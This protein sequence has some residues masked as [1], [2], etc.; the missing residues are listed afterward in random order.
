MCVFF[1]E[2]EILTQKIELSP[3]QLFVLP[4]QRQQLLIV[5]GIG[6]S[7]RSRQSYAL[8]SR[9]SRESLR[10]SP[11]SLHWHV[12][13][14]SFIPQSL[15][16]TCFDIVILWMFCDASCCFKFSCFCWYGM[17]FAE[18]RAGSTRWGPSV[19]QWRMPRIPDTFLIL[20]KI[21]FHVYNVYNSL[22]PASSSVQYFDSECLYKS[23]PITGPWP[24]ALACS[25]ATVSCA[26]ESSDFKRVTSGQPTG[27]LAQTVSTHFD[28]KVGVPTIVRKTSWQHLS[29]FRFST[30]YIFLR[31]CTVDCSI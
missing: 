29:I 11:G 25:L 7:R 1:G 17:K 18:S 8:P 4:L 12:F 24:P 2:L 27:T 3:L 21:S 15:I 16:D 13:F 26:W 28:T 23:M 19:R 5:L 14:Q 22:P 31:H 20:M 10:G 30:F 6:Q 9:G